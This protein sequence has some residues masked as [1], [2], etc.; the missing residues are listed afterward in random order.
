MESREDSFLINFAPGDFAGACCARALRLV[1]KF[2]LFGNFG[3][4]SLL[5][6]FSN[7]KRKSY[8]A[9][10]SLRSPNIGVGSLL[11]TEFRQTYPA[12]VTHTEP[13]IGLIL[14]MSCPE[15]DLF[16]FFHLCFL[17]KLP[18]FKIQTLA[19]FI[20][21]LGLIWLQGGFLLQ[22]FRAQVYVGLKL[23]ITVAMQDNVHSQKSLIWLI[24]TFE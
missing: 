21:T 3:F 14:T 24:M 9:T 8:L 22:L 23:I 7:R 16:C 1:W 12:T 19:I 4:L 20:Q 13:W 5:A 18:Y 6:G 15:K 10:S 2:C 17:K 11:I